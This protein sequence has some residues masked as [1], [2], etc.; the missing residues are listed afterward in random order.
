VRCAF[1]L[2]RKELLTFFFF[3]L[4]MAH[5]LLLTP[6]LLMVANGMLQTLLVAAYRP[7]ILAAT[8]NISFMYG[9]YKQFQLQNE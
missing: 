6:K 8:G 9:I 7:L 4:S 5:T 1:I 3:L 2:E